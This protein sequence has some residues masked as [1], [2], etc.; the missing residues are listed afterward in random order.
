[1]LGKK[2]KRKRKRQMRE[3]ALQGRADNDKKESK[4]DTQNK[5]I[6]KEEQYQSQTTSHTDIRVRK[7]W[8]ELKRESVG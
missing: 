3:G 4:I 8:Y 7:V 1:M 2:K 6:Y 5:T